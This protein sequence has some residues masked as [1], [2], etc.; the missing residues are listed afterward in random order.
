[1]AKKVLYFPTQGV[2]TTPVALLPQGQALFADGRPK[3]EVA[4]RALYE[5]RPSLTEQIASFWT[6]TCVFLGLASFL[7]SVS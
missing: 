1:M 3:S 6:L 5:T 7:A 2:I 4:K